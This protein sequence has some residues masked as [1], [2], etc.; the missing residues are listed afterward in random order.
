MCEASFTVRVAYAESK[1]AIST[2]P[3]TAT[4]AAVVLT[5]GRLLSEPICDALYLTARGQTQVA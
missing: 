2:T 4:V 3:I 5:L 1:H